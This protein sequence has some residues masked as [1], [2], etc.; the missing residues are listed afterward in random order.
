[1]QLGAAL[2]AA[3]CVAGLAAVV[4]APGWRAA[5]LLAATVILA[6]ADLVFGP[7]AIALAEAA[8][9]PAARGRYLAAFQYAFTAAG[10]LA[11]AVVALYSVAVWLPW[12]LVASSATLEILG[13]RQLASR[14]PA[15]ALRPEAPAE[16]GVGGLPD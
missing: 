12:V 5:E 9:P 6:A 3:W 15:S 13:L 14:L 11:P 7:R 16:P 2:Y 1:M 10:V 4:V 8:A